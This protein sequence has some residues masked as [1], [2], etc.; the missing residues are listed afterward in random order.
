MVYKMLMVTTI[1]I[2]LIIAIA[3]LLLSIYLRQAPTG[4][5]H[6]TCDIPQYG[7][8]E[9]TVTV[10]IEGENWGAK[11]LQPTEMTLNIFG[12]SV[13]CECKTI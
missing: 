9:A 1:I 12:Y 5:Y 2:T 13:P 3:Y 10:Q 6:C 8:K 4:V 7:K 11:V